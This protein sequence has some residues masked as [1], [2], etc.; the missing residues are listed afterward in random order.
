[1][2]IIEILYL[3]VCGIGTVNSGFLSIYLFFSKKGNRLLNSY[4]A[5]IILTFSLR[6]SKYLWINLF[7]NSHPFLHTIW[8]PAF[9]I[10]GFL[11]FIYFSLLNS[12]KIKDQV[13]PITYIFLG[14]LLSFIVV[15]GVNPLG[16]D[17]QFLFVIK[18]SFLLGLIFSIKPINETLNKTEKP[19]NQL[20]NWIFSLLIFFSIIF[21]IYT[22]IIF[23]RFNVMLVESCIFSVAIYLLIFAEI[24]YNI[25]T[26]V[27]KSPAKLNSK[28]AEIV[29]KLNNLMNTEKLY[30]DPNLTLQI[31]ASRLSVSAHNLS[32]LINSNTGQNYN[33]FVNQF[34]IREV[35]NILST[36]GNNKKISAIAFESGFNSVSVFNSSFKKFVGKT[37]SKFASDANNT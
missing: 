11:C 4:L 29:E 26:K 24:K 13:K 7:E 20:K 27:H 22:L 37:P 21:L 30:L 6:V 14:T 25:L 12:Q 35:T 1:M 23:I 8:F 19:D 16:D 9:L 31:L 18:F 2:N 17:H 36:S 34:R 10:L 32:R 33:D 5:L 15:Y 28:D 3:I